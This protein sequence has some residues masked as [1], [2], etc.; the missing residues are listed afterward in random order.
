MNSPLSLAAAIALA[1]AVLAPS[2][3]HAADK[4]ATTST[5][6]T[7]TCETTVLPSAAR[8]DL[9]AS[10]QVSGRSLLGQLVVT[11]RTVVTVDAVAGDNYAYFGVPDSTHTWY[12]LTPVRTLTYT[13]RW[14]GARERLTQKAWIHRSALEQ[15][16][17]WLRCE[18][19]LP[20]VPPT[21]V[22]Q[23]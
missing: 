14:S 8:L 21:S 13:N 3:T 2:A 22:P 6:T 5:A 17:K 10:P 20:F 23:T 1:A 18:P 7:S 12:E 16:P 19:T 11:K 9:F 15:T 4:T